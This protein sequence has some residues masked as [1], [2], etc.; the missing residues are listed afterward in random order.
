VEE[1]G[2]LDQV[3]S[4]QRR[5]E[6]DAQVQESVDVCEAMVGPARSGA[7]LTEPIV[8][9][10]HLPPPLL[11]LLEN[12]SLRLLCLR[13][14]NKKREVVHLLLLVHSEVEPLLQMMP[15]LAQPLLHLCT[16][17]RFFFN[18]SFNLFL[19][20]IFDLSGEVYSSFTDLTTSS[21][22]WRDLTAA[23]HRATAW[24]SIFS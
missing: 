6:C 2:Q 8:L 4:F 18:L 13:T 22:V 16:E 20:Y 3:A 23:S 12:T 10:Q 7:G 11:N 14:M 15:R 17:Y 9:D 24:A 5:L 21:A 1:D 19:F